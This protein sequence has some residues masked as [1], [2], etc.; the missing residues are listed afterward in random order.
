[1][2]FCECPLNKFHT[3]MTIIAA[4]RQRTARL[5]PT[6]TPKTRFRRFFKTENVMKGVHKVPIPLSFK[7]G[8]KSFRHVYHLTKQ[9]YFFVY[10]KISSFAR[11]P[12]FGEVTQKSSVQ[13]PIEYYLIV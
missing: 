10:K 5:P 2:L 9:D 3:A 11:K 6:L 13:T 12:G 4:P 8:K 1:M 7:K